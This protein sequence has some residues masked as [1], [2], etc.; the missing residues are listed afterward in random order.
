MDELAKALIEM[1]EMLTDGSSKI[2]AGRPWNPRVMKEWIKTV[3]APTNALGHE[4]KNVSSDLKK[5][6]R[7]LGD[8]E[9]VYSALMNARGSL[10]AISAYLRMAN[11]KILGALQYV[12]MAEE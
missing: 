5:A 10:S 3:K 9:A 11:D 7:N 2:A 8:R 4:W 6:E 1:A 12:D